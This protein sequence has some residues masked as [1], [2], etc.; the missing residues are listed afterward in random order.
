MPANSERV[1][2]PAPG[3]GEV[4]LGRCPRCIGREEGAGCPAEEPARPPLKRKGRDSGRVC[5]EDEPTE[6]ASCGPPYRLR[7][8]D[9][10]LCRQVQ[11]AVADVLQQTMAAK[12]HTGERRTSLDEQAPLNAPS[13]PSTLLCTS[14]LSDL[15]CW[16]VDEVRDSD[17]ASLPM[18]HRALHALLARSVNPPSAGPQ[19]S[20]PTTGPGSCASH[21]Q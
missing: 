13:L 18:L 2:P 12:K 15:I 1:P 3:S 19:L 20:A 7:S 8:A 17:P 4:Q 11:A 14:E 21:P 10:S 16:A 6:A 9:H 5:W